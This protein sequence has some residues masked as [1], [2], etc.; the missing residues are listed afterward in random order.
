M[1]S[2]TLRKRR[3]NKRGEQSATGGIVGKTKRASRS[4]PGK[5]SKKDSIRSQ[6][7]NPDALTADDLSALTSRLYV[8]DGNGSLSPLRYKP[9][10]EGVK[11]PEELDELRESLQKLVLS[12]T[13]AASKLL[14]DQQPTREFAGLLARS[15]VSLVEFAIQKTPRSIQAMRDYIAGRGKTGRSDARLLQSLIAAKE[16]QKM[17]VYDSF[18]SLK[19]EVDNVMASAL[20]ERVNLTP[21]EIQRALNDYGISEEEAYTIKAYTNA[22]T[23]DLLSKKFG[24]AREGWK[25]MHTALDK[26]PSTG[27]LG[28]VHT[29]FRVPRQRE[30]DRIEALSKGT[31]VLHGYYRMEHGQR[32]YLSTATT[33]NVHTTST[34]IAMTGSMVEIT[35]TSGKYINPFGVQSSSVDGA[36]VLYLPGTLSTYVGSVNRDGLPI[37]RFTEVPHGENMNPV[38]AEDGGYTEVANP[39]GPSSPPTP[40]FNPA[41]PKLKTE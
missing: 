33:F 3:N 2:S 36:E 14:R 13:K 9:G 24:D 21:E 34:R 25:V 37:H 7:N 23:N 22:H 8:D 40:A 4:I 19:T 16:L 27:K 29:G 41:G 10:I 39:F 26:L 20:Q 35:G 32:H 6:L 12:R 30:G 31:Q 1:N 17:G 38:V 18:L 5:D 28:L 11:S 15:G